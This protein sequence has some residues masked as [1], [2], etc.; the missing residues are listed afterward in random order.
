VRP[1]PAPTARPVPWLA[2]VLC[3]LLL[4]VACSGAS[5][6][7]QG[8]PSP[9]AT[10]SASAE[11]VATIAAV[12]DIACN[13]LPSQ[14]HRRCRY[15]K[16]AALIRRLAPDRFLALGDLQY[17]HGSLDDFERY[18]DRYFGDLK[19]ITAPAPGN[20]ETYTKDMRGYLDY[21]GAIA[22]PH[23]SWSYPN[24]GGYYSFDLGGWHVIALN[25]QACK[26][27]TWSPT[28]GRGVPI[29]SNA[30]HT[31]GDRKSVV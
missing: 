8:S 13:S 15:N 9:T 2:L 21:F 7:R 22:R 12:G 26:G 29:S 14:H 30:I 11:T 24:R 18:Y 31:N 4:A 6:P 20:H 27:S 1:P 10:T 23:G 19:S 28:E 16:V 25:S 3:L 5:S 17:L